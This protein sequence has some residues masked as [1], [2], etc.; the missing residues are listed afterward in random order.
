MPFQA[1]PPAAPAAA[2]AKI[3]MNPPDEFSG[4]PTKLRN[5]L[6]QVKL[7]HLGRS[8]ISEA[9]KII[10]ALSFMVGGNAESWAE[11]QTNAYEMLGWA[12][13]DWAV[14]EQA[15]IQNFGDL[16]PKS[17]A[18]LK[19]KD[20]RQGTK[21]AEDYNINFSRWAHDT[22]YGQEALITIYKDG[23]N[24]ALLRQI[25]LSDRQPT[26]FQ[27]WQ[28]R[29]AELD[30]RHREYMARTSSRPQTRNTRITN[31][32]YRQGPPAGPS[33][34]STPAAP[35]IKQEEKAVSL[36]GIP[37]GACFNCGR[38]G[39]F[40]SS[41]PNASRMSTSGSGSR[42]FTPAARGRG[43]KRFGQGRNVRVVETSASIEEVNSNEDAR[44]D[45]E[46]CGIINWDSSRKEGLKRAL[47]KQ[48]F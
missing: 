21:T 36:G 6:R 22:G 13:A 46:K 45:F 3:K 47:E 42:S 2:P 37:K 10:Y 38:F 30:R 25:Y 35:R 41:C 14:F 23:L 16:D 4:D 27:E 43:G 9:G 8:G 18:Q 32:P 24:S 29:A 12:G 1:P 31:T 40:A 48:G 17:T 15:L 28:S 33:T 20:V 34:Q 5:F 7:N 19:I 44:Q 39:H 11:Q 26:T